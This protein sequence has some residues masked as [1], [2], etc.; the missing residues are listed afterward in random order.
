MPQ[1]IFSISF[2]HGFLKCLLTQG[3][4]VKAHRVIMA[5]P[6]FFREGLVRDTE[7][8][9]A[10]LKTAAAEMGAKSAKVIGAVPGF[11]NGL[12]VL[13][14]PKAQGLDPDVVIPKEAARTMGVS[15]DISMLKWRRLDDSADRQ[16]WVALSASR[17][18]INV[19]AETAKL[20]KLKV[21]SMELRPFALARAVN[22]PNAIIAWVAPDGCEV[23]IVRNSTPVSHQAVFWGAEPVEGTV[24]VYRLNEILER[25]ITAYDTEST[26]GALPADTSVYVTGSPISLDPTIADKVAANLQ[27]T[28]GI[29]MPP[30]RLPDD[31]PVHDFVVN[32]GMAL[33][34]A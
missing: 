30:L 15:P 17:R 10:I 23:V 20:A 3:L 14:L 32:I 24:L 25:I 33:G 4:E 7:R 16:R 2:E 8:I 9:G 13:E 19:F 26:Q 29:L 34:E 1:H 6:A 31:F 28:A 12:R 22:E 27:R 21:K 11:Q 18:A 5:S